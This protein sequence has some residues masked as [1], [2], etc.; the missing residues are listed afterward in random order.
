MNPSSTP[1]SAPQPTA[2]S[3]SPLPLAGRRGLILGVA[4][5]HSIAF[6]EAF[7]YTVAGRFSHCGFKNGVWQGTL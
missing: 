1:D 4:N 3:A 6:H 2:P 7:G 5:E